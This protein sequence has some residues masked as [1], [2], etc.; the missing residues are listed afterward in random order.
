MPY[1]TTRQVCRELKISRWQVAKLIK[2]GRLAAIKGNGV[3]G[4][5]RIDQA[6]LTAFV[7]DSKVEANA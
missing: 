3:N 6:S 1:L 5:Y 4:H 2:S 7:E